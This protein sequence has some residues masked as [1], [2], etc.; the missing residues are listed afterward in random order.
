MARLSGL[1]RDVL[2]LYRQCLRAVR[3]KPAE[4]RA[5]FKELA[6]SEFR[7]Y[8]GIDRKDFGTIEFLLRRGQRQLETYSDPGI[9]NVSR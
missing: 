7:Q 6:R 3:D 9:R 8:I 2:A 1:Q 5:N 4:T